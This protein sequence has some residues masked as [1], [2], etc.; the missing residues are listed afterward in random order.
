[1]FGVFLVGAYQE[2]FGD[3]NNLFGDTNELIVTLD[4]EGGYRIE[5]V[6]SGDT[7][8]DVLGYVG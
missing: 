5:E 6:Q 2:N 8:T 1:M 4:P 3:L 7:V